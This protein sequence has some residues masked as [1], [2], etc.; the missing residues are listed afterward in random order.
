MIRL[1]VD[2][3]EERLAAE[4][5]AASARLRDTLH[6]ATP[7][8]WRTVDDRLAECE[9]LNAVTQLARHLGRL[10]GQLVVVEEKAE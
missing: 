6:A 3:W 2:D 7:G 4:R 10:T 5:H 1:L 8:E 9:T